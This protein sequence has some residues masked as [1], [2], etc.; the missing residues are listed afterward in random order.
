[1]CERVKRAGGRVG[2]QVEKARL[3]GQK[4]KMTKSP[5]ACVY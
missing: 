4:G 3:Y 5:P 2:W 1:M